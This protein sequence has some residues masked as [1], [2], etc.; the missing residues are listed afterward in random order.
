VISIT[1]MADQPPTGVFKDKLRYARNVRDGITKDN[2]FLPVIYEFPKAMIKTKAYEEPENFYIT[3]PYIGRTDWGREWIANEL[4]KEKQ[5]GLETRN[6]FLAKFLNIEIG[7][8]LR[9]DSWAGAEFWQAA[10]DTTLTLESLL[11]RSDVAV[12]G[13]DGG[14]LDDLLGLCVI[15]REKLTRKWLVWCKAWARRI[16]LERRKEIASKL[17]DLEASG[18]LSI[19]DDLS[20]DDVEELADIVE[21]VR[22]SGLLPEEASIGADPAGVDDIVDELERRSF[23]TGSDD[24][25]GEIIS[26]TGQGGRA[27]IIATPHGP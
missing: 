13:V 2:K 22:D 10:A 24:E 18:C 20:S 25:V 19:V 1:T 6:V 5:K 27:Q 14:G 3:N 12:I 11:E 21:Q 8:G 15:G 16:V 7:Q 17:L 9:T 23:S 4:S 26:V